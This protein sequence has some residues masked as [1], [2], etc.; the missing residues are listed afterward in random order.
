MVAQC[1]AIKIFGATATDA[2]SF[3]IRMRGVDLVL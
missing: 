2:Q 3:F 1:I